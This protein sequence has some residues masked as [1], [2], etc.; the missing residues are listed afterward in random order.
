MDDE[1]L[2]FYGSGY[3]YGGVN[4]EVQK[5]KEEESA[6]VMSENE[7]ANEVEN[8]EMKKPIESIYDTLNELADGDYPLPHIVKKGIKATAEVHKQTYCNM[9]KLHHKVAQATLPLVGK[10]HRPLVQ[11]V[12]FCIPSTLKPPGQVAP[13]PPPDDDDKDDDKDKDDEKKDNTTV[14]PPTPPP[15]V[16][17]TPPPAPPPAA[18]TKGAEEFASVLKFHRMVAVI[19]TITMAFLNLNY[20]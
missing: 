19:S 12:N 14:D 15:P 11:Y 1:R 10:H 2:D 8:V 7:I 16:P 3:G 6:S 13:P 4:S 20:F 17:P 18:E 9:M 5:T